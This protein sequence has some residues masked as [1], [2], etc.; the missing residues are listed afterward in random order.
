MS[1][2]EE[3]FRQGIAR[4]EAALGYRFTDP[5]L[6][7]EALT[8]RSFANENGVCGPDNERLE[9]LGDAVLELVVSERL[10]RMYPHMSEGELTRARA[11]VVRTSSLAAAASALELGSVVRLGKGEEATGGR[12]KDSVLANT[13]E[14]LIGAVFFEA[15]MAKAEAVTLHL[16]ESRFGAPEDLVQPAAKNRLQELLQARHLPGPRYVT[17]ERN[18]PDHAALFSVEVYSGP[19]LLA[20]GSGSSKKEATTVAAQAALAVLDA[21]P[22]PCKGKA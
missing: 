17:A 11:A 7:A 6:P 10:F 15:G 16:L 20:R 19:R 22:G 9:F 2:E 18:G 5:A 3:R 12:T 1:L 21:E 8:H 13:V 4:V 14:A